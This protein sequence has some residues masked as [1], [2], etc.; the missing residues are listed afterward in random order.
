MALEVIKAHLWKSL[1][2]ELRLYFRMLFRVW[3]TSGKTRP[4]RSG[5]PR[6]QYAR[7]LGNEF[8]GDASPKGKK[9]PLKSV[10]TT[11]YSDFAVKGLWP[12]C[13]ELFIWKKQGANKAPPP[14]PFPPLPSR[15]LRHVKKL[16]KWKDLAT[17]AEEKWIIIIKTSE[18][19]KFRV[20]FSELLFCEAAGIVN[21]INRKWKADFQTDLRELE[22]LLPSFFIKT[23]SSLYRQQKSPR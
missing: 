4:V 21:L 16:R 11:A 7:Y 8:G 3:N 14:P 23:P 19:S 18:G 13:L 17:E 12:R 5:F 1:S 2:L 15:F 20:N 6:H 10:F 22:K 9:N